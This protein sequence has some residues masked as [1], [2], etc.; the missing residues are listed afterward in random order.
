MCLPSGNLVWSVCPRLRQLCHQCGFV[1]TVE[2]KKAKSSILFSSIHKNAFQFPGILV[3]GCTRLLVLL[4]GFSLVISLR[5]FGI[6]SSQ[7][8]S[9]LLDFSQL[10]TVA[11]RSD[12]GVRQMYAVTVECCTRWQHIND[13]R[14]I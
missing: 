7:T 5:P 8:M 10:W 11:I 12:I 14:T 13:S 1:C 2:T 6:F 3:S 9:T 4:P